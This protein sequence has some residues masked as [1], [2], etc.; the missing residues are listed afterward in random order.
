MPASDINRERTAIRR[1]GLS[2]PMRLAVES[3]IVR[4]GVTVF[5]YGCGHGDDIRRLKSSGITCQGWD[6]HFRPDIPRQAAHVVNLGFVLN[7]IEDPHERNR[8][9]A[10]A[11][12][13]TER[14]LLVAVRTHSEVSLSQAHEF[15]DGLVTHRSTF[16]RLYGHGELR[17][18]I[19][20]VLGTSI[21]SVEPGIV[22][23]FRNSRDRQDFLAQHLRQTR[24]AQGRIRQADRLY[25]RH[26]EAIDS[27]LNFYAYHGRAPKA[28]EFVYPGLL[29]EIGSVGAS[30]NILR[31]L[32]GRDKLT[33]LKTAVR[34][35]LVV[36]VALTRFGDRPRFGELP[37]HLR[38]DIRAHFGTYRAACEQGD[39]LLFETGNQVLIDAECRDS[40]V[41]K[42]TPAALYVHRT[43]LRGLSPH[44]RIYEGC[45]RVFIGDVPDASIVKLARREPRVSYL[46]Y[47]TFDTDPH[48]TL[49]ESYTVHLRSLTASYRS[50]ADSPN[51]PILHR[52]EAMVGP[53]YPHRQKFASLSAQE[54]RWGLLE[55]S[56]SIGTRESWERRLRD[57]GVQIR[58]HRLVRRP[59]CF[60]TE[61]GRSANATTSTSRGVDWA[62]S[63]ADGRAT[64]RER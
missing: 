19:E 26:R 50:Y 18:W 10:D 14:V 6:P 8:V 43:S 24:V 25:D 4:P 12:A 16:Q 36:H 34:E 28:D 32:V 5:D 33:E 31:R 40:E 55:D 61:S 45:A 29:K 64:G 2:R 52:K 46:S 20:G 59:R 57:A 54:E 58:G 60:A 17:N 38:Y 22:F 39:R 23:V 63:V 49:Y 27:L 51:P 48:P 35:D 15:G 13:L 30:V 21:V 11:W 3:G 53:L 1:T 47:P 62:D 44:L 7:V 9:L 37:D 42:L 41:G 56:A